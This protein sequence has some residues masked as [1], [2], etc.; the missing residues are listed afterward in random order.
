[1]S[2]NKIQMLSS[3]LT[4][5]GLNNGFCIFDWHVIGFVS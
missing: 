4:G 2:E 1:M 3:E 5:D